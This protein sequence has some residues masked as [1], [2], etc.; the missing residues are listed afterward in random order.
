MGLMKGGIVCERCMTHY[1]M[2]DGGGGWW[3]GWKIKFEEEK[4][5]GG[6]LAALKEYNIVLWRVDGHGTST[7]K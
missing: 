3:N 2:E 4:N 5:W 7:E 6:C 1:L